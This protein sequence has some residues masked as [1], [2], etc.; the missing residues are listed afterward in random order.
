[1][2]RLT[3][4]KP[5]E[6]LTPKLAEQPPV[7]YLGLPACF[8]AGEI[9]LGDRLE[10]CPEG[11]TVK[12]RHGQQ[13]VTAATDNYGDFE[14]KNLMADTQYVLSIEQAGYR[15]RELRVHTSAD[16]NVGTIVMEPAA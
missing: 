1:V 10:E 7:G 3:A 4:E 12:L 13:T 11:V 16:P 6:A 8:V 9:V 2:A 5:I 14:F 15:S